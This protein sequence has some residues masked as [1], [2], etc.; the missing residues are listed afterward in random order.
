MIYDRSLT[1]GPNLNMNGHLRS[2][3]WKYVYESED[4]LETGTSSESEDELETATS[5]ELEDELET[6]LSSESEDEQRP[7]DKNQILSDAV[8]IG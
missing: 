4:K 3:D 8:T 5:S 1:G 6:G 7:G 2:E